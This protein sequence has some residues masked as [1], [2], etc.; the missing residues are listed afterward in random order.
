MAHFQFPFGALAQLGERFHGMEEVI[1]SIPI[2]STKSRPPRG[3][4]FAEETT[5]CLP[6]L[7][8][9]TFASDLT[10]S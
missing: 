4:R 5:P 2:S 10:R 1:G 3:G 7:T 6:L 8:M 9:F